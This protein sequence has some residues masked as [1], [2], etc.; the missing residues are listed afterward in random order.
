[1]RFFNYNLM[2]CQVDGRQAQ[3]DACFAG[4]CRTVCVQLNL[5]TVDVS[6]LR[7]LGIAAIFQDCSVYPVFNPGLLETSSL[8]DQELVLGANLPTLCDAL[9]DI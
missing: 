8:M 9:A 6:N 3:E 2:S 1:M 7:V 5:F 4:S